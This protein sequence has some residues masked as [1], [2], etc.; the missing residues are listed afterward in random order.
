MYLQGI[1][2]EEW[3]RPGHSFRQI[4]LQVQERVREFEGVRFG[5]DLPR[6]LLGHLTRAQSNTALA[7]KPVYQYV[8]YVKPANLE[9]SPL[10]SRCTALFNRRGCPLPWNKS[11]VP[12]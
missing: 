8:L 12:S 2:A 5:S 9:V 1:D 4:D 11:I 10:L 7:A 6:V 3:G